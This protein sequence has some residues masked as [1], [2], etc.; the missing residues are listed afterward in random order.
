MDSQAWQCAS[1]VNSVS[2]S[3]I[4]WKE[5]YEGSINA[6]GHSTADE[7]IASSMTRLLCYT[8]CRAKVVYL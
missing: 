7:E 6:N 3:D 5:S 2:G 4:L 1:Y 8:S